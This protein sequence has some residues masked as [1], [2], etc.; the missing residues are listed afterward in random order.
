M[1]RQ[2]HRHPFRLCR[3]RGNGKNMERYFGY[4]SPWQ[5]CST[6]RPDICSSALIASGKIVPTIK[7]STDTNVHQQEQLPQTNQ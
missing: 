4:S 7:G 6:W 5:K 1:R 2:R 3:R